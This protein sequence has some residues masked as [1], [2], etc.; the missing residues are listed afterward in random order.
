MEVE[1]EPR[2]DVNEDEG[3]PQ[4]VETRMFQKLVIWQNQQRIGE[5][6]SSHELH[7]MDTVLRAYYEMGWEVDWDVLW[8]VDYN[9]VPFWLE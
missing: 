9:M 1:L 3:A 2:R 8:D 6:S 4:A 7:G 5:E